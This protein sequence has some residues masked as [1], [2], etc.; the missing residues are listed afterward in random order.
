M[1]LCRSR[2]LATNPAQGGAPGP[3][4]LR[5]LLELHFLAGP[6]HQR[7]A[8]AEPPTGPYFVTTFANERSGVV[9][10][11]QRQEFHHTPFAPPELA[12]HA[13]DQSMLST[14]KSLASSR[15]MACCT[16]T[17]LTWSDLM[18]WATR[19]AALR[20]AQG[21]AFSTYAGAWASPEARV[22]IRAPRSLSPTAA[23]KLHLPVRAV[24]ERQPHAEF[25]ALPVGGDDQEVILRG[26]SRVCRQRH[27]HDFRAEAVAA[28]ADHVDD[29]L[30]VPVD[31]IHLEDLASFFDSCCWMSA[32]PTWYDLLECFTNSAAL[33]ITTTECFSAKRTGPKLAVLDCDGLC[34]GDDVLDVECRGSRGRV[35]TEPVTAR[36]AMTP[37]IRMTSSTGIGAQLVT[38]GPGK[39]PQRL[40]TITDTTTIAMTSR[41]QVAWQ[42]AKAAKSRTAPYLAKALGRVRT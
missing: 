10:H 13:D 33:R 15:V 22:T 37:T 27:G 7:Q 34:P 14:W 21:P 4:G 16:A 25:A 36:A 26:A 17:S 11:P 23:D 5:T 40:A 29:H 31:R 1:R 38:C 9:V 30:L 42:G 41:C 18:E 35:W 12:V 8:S 24:D 39:A 20:N 2:A 3:P 28:V 32:A 6:R 19:S